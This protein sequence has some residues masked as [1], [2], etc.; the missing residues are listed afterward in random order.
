MAGKPLVQ[1][2]KNR[3]ASRYDREEIERRKKF[4][5]MEIAE[6]KRRKAR[7]RERR[8]ERFYDKTTFVGLDFYKKFFSFSDEEIAGKKILDAGAGTGQ[9]A[10]D[11]EGVG[12]RVVSL[13]P[14]YKSTRY[15]KMLRGKYATTAGIVEK[16]P[17]RNESFDIAFA[18]RLIPT[19]VKGIDRYRGIKELLRVVK[20]GGWIGIGPFVGPRSVQDYRILRIK[21]FFRN[22]GFR[23]TVN[24]VVVPT[25]TYMEG[26]SR[27]KEEIDRRGKK[28]RQTYLIIQN[29]GNIARLEEK[30]AEPEKRKS[31][32]M[33]NPFNN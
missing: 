16:L 32:R 6:Q 31:V 33:Q 28:Q 24:N 25:P 22:T 23:F 20:K 15:G 9:F 8:G 27:G 18:R 29:T 4:K 10:V 21:D 17:Y 30:I 7:H 14:A 12:A 26:G 5:K 13:S 11:A 2:R 1:K 19:L 3:R